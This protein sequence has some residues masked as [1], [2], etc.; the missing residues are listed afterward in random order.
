MKEP[1]SEELL[2]AYVDEELSADERA[3]IEHWLAQSPEARAKVD[4][5]RRLS[6]VF[7]ELP[8]TEVPQEFPVKV[9]Q[10]A[11][12]RMLLPEEAAVLPRRIL[13]RWGVAIG[14]M[15]ATAA[16]LLLILQATNRDPNLPVQAF[17]VHK[18]ANAPAPA[19]G[20]E[21]ASGDL[22]DSLHKEGQLVAQ[23]ERHRSDETD[24]TKAAAPAA[25]PAALVT[26][27]KSIDASRGSVAGPRGADT[28]GAAADSARP[29]RLPTSRRVGVAAP[30]GHFAR[31]PLESDAEGRVFCESATCKDQAG[32]RIR[33]RFGY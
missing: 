20:N 29:I 22:G 8:R 11:E 17:A 10:L 30:N 6:A 26:S 3:T 9:L 21:I 5:F 4:D 23:S 27:R 28:S 18:I 7:A 1:I 12:R 31:R 13:R 24:G 33:Q 19:P 32:D 2:S 25:P 14:V 16:G 15:A